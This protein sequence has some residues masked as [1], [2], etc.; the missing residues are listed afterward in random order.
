MTTIVTPAVVPD[1]ITI[2]VTVEDILT[3]TPRNGANCA[4]AVAVKRTFGVDYV[5]VETDGVVE[6]SFPDEYAQYRDGPEVVEFIAAF[7]SHDPAH[8]A[9]A[10]PATFTLWRM[11][12][13]EDED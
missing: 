10:Q 2:D 8:H 4:I 1:S 12:E 6:I 5:Q 7:D 3:A 13:Y 9:K 11:P